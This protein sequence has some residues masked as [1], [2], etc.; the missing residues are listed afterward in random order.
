MP[1]ASRLAPALFF[2]LVLVLALAL[3]LSNGREV[4]S[5][6]TL[7]ARYLPLEILRGRTDLTDVPFF[8][9]ARNAYF[10]A[11]HEG[12]LDSAFPIGVAFLAV[13]VYALPAWLG[14]VRTDADLDFYAK[15]AAALLTALGVAALSAAR[16]PHARAAA[17]LM[18][19][20]TP[21]WTIAS[22]GL[23]SHTG[24]TAAFAATLLFAT[25]GWP[26]AAGL[27]AGVAGAVR[28]QLLP[29]VAALGIAAYAFGRP[30]S[31]G[32]L[33]RF[34]VAS[35]L[36]SIPLVARDLVIFG[37][38]F[39]WFEGYRHAA[40]WSVHAGLPITDAPS[41]A[42]RVLEGM[43]GLLVSPSRGL[44]FF[45]PWLLLGLAPRRLGAA[46]EARWLRASAAALLAILVVHTVIARWYGG[47]TYGPR[48]LTD[49]APFLA[50]LAIGPLV[51]L[52]RSRG[53][54]RLGPALAV[55]LVAASI[56]AQAVG[57]FCYEPAI[58]NAKPVPIDE[59][60]RRAFDLAGS[61]VPVALESGLARRGFFGHEQSYALAIARERAGDLEG[62]RR[63]AL[64]GLEIDPCS[65]ACHVV[66]GEVARVT[67]RRDDAR[68]HFRA[69]LA[70]DPESEVAAIGLR[71]VE[72]ERG[73]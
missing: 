46:P 42:G 10:V 61:Q 72:D 34:A 24:G 44:L 16:L 14:R 38:P 45:A 33:L 32:D 58:W 22:Q 31:F 69:A 11:D 7:P 29:A 49:A 43:A 30:R 36:P 68:R 39:G 59:D 1:S 9:A 26:F 18:A 8:D 71:L 57:A 64:R 56:F 5:N 53:A 17:A 20:A 66:A 47:W 21:A 62:A 40:G 67:G 13:P 50:V 15:L 2:V 55:L 63:L 6:D 54:L 37:R 4:S 12:R 60:P 73:P 48:F 65:I 23:W 35:T 41:F 27:C 70:L 52:F 19:C 3:F 28:P 51:T 25:R